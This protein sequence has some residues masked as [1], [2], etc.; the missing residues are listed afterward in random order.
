[1]RELL[2]MGSIH[3]RSGRATVKVGD[4][5]PTAGLKLDARG[6]LTLR[7]RDEIAGM[8]GGAEGTKRNNFEPQMNTDEH[9]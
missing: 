7:L 5:I 6:E 8:L 3:I 1:M 2:P 9:R 4:P